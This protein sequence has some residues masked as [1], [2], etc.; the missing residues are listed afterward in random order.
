[1]IFERSLSF[2]PWRTWRLLYETL[3]EGGSLKRAIVV[4]E[5]R[6]QIGN[7]ESTAGICCAELKRLP[8]RHHAA[9]VL[10]T[11]RKLWKRLQQHFQF[12]TG[13]MKA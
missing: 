3:R 5:N 4:R 6:T 8:T 11:W 2:L 9:E 1:M 13:L 7:T 10:A 12:L